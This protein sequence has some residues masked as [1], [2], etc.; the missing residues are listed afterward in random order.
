MARTKRYL[1]KLKYRIVTVLIDD[2]IYE[3]AKV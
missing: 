1:S 2:N 3:N